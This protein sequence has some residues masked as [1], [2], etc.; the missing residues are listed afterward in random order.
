MMTRNNPMAAKTLRDHVTEAHKRMTEPKDISP[1]K[2]THARVEKMSDGSGYTTDVTCKDCG[3]KH[4]HGH[5]SVHKSVGKVASH[6]KMAFEGQKGGQ[7]IKDPDDEGNMGP[8]AEDEE[9][10]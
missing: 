4:L 1:G 8:D 3:E 7:A 9:E 6:L 2:A 5:T 10:D